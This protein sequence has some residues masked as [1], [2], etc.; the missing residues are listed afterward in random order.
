MNP[1]REQ[2]PVSKFRF[3]D[4]SPGTKTR[5]ELV[6]DCLPDGQ[7]LVFSTLILRGKC[8]GKTF[9][10]TGGVHGDEYEGP[11]AIQDVFDELDPQLLKGTFVAIPILNTPAFTAAT[12][13]GGWDHQNLARIFPGS[14]AGTVSERIAHAFSTYIVG[15]ADFY[16]D[17]HAGG[18][19]YR[20]KRFAGYQIVDSQSNAV[21]RAAAIAWGFDLVWGTGGLPGRSLSAARE[22]GVP[23][24]YVEMP[25]EGRCRPIDRAHA[26]KGLR[27]LLAYLDMV[28]GDFP[29][30][31]PQFCFE[32]GTVGSGHL[33]VDY[34]SPTSGLFVPAVEV[35]DSVVKGQ[36]LGQIRHPDGTVL[37]DVPSDH[38][39][40]V[41]FLRTQPRVFAGDCLVFV[42]EVPIS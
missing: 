39:G 31:P 10:T 37:A 40:R 34:P 16:A 17:L 18:N 21:Q 6:V 13:E 28:P 7:P 36:S 27:N 22:R 4:I 8:A 3:E 12:R 9:L 2:I 15:Q 25:G 35:W 23:A 5:L 20:I 26:Q 32:T 1:T 41:L 19:G 38:A 11:V 29:T 30:A 24:I 42:L 33:Q 14:P